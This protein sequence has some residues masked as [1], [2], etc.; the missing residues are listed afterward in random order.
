MID[1]FSSTAIHGIVTDFKWSAYRR[2][3]DIGGALGS[4]LGV[5]LQ[6]NQKC[7]GVLFDQPR[8]NTTDSLQFKYSSVPA[9]VPADM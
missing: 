8:V 1:S 6:N 4:V 3:I 5:V 7:E 2:V 9:D